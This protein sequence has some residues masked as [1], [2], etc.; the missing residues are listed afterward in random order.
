MITEAVHPPTGQAAARSRSLTLPGVLRFQLYFAGAAFVSWT[1]LRVI[2]WFR[3]K[4]AAAP[5][6]D[7]IR[8][9]LAGMHVDAAMAFI[10]PVALIG[11][12]GLLASV[13]WLA[14][15]PLKFATPR[16]R[17]IPLWRILFQSVASVCCLAAVFLLIS[18]WFFFDEFESRFNTVAIDYLLYTH[19]VFTNIRESYPVPAIIAACLVFGGGMAWGAFRF[20]RPDWRGIAVQLQVLG[21]SVLLTALWFVQVYLPVPFLVPAGILV[22]AL[23]AV[24]GWHCRRDRRLGLAVAWLAVAAAGFFS[25]RPAE[26][27]FSVHRVINEL[28]N[29]GWASAIRAAWSRHLEFTAFYVT[30]PRDEAFR[31]A[32]RLLAEPG[33]TFVGPEVP[34]APKPDANGVIDEAADEKWLDAA[35]LSL[36]RD[37]A[38]DPSKPQR[39]VCILLEES[40]GSEFFGCLGRV[41]KEGRPHTLTPEM[42]RLAAD[43]GLLFTNIFADGNR[44]IRGFEGVFSSFPP[45]PGDSIL[46]RDKTER[47]ETIARILKRDGY[48]TLFLY[49]GR[50][51]FDYIT[52]YTQPNGW[53]G[54]IEEKHFENPTHTTA[55]GVCDE[56]LFHRGIEEMRRLHRTG[57]PFL[58]SFMTVSN[59]RPYTC[60]PGRVPDLPEENGRD[61]V[62]RYADWALGDFFRRAKK[63]AF[64]NDTIFI[65]VGDHGARVYGSQTIPLQSYR[66]P[67][68]VAGPCVVPKA[69]RVD[70]TGCQ[71]DVAPTIL[72]LLGR[73]YRTL[74]YGHDL[75][76]PGAEERQKCLMH[77]N[78]SIAIYRSGRQVVYGLNKSLEYWEGDAAAGKMARV[79][80]PDEAF[81]VLQQDG[82]ALFVTADALYTSRRYILADEK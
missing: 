2:L 51:T 61:Y 63:E 72:G 4:P 38:G 47:V 12:S 53:D 65:V 64:W 13:V 42:D 68:L 11:F 29:N 74:L 41:D 27:N 1:L 43:E 22:I 35:R 69:Q 16:F 45:L 37:V 59:H 6:W 81:T 15:G 79:Q 19:E 73:P 75:L 14:I 21:I 18:E 9:F 70:V 78:R 57:K 28:S 55:W 49:G 3:F 20:A 76:K 39:N 26:T 62:V 24:I 17:S 80:N 8:V 31:R 36:T 30:M 46:A 54:L 66:V 60:P 7:H 52:S 10:A 50:G 82:T 34:D 40:L 58:A 33:V 56:D 67:F 44:T 25:V 77:H 48:Q 23:A 71:L 32:R 5:A